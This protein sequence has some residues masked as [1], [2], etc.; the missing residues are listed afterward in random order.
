MNEF[1]L[2]RRLAPELLLDWLRPM[3]GFLESQGLSWSEIG[4]SP[5]DCDSLAEILM[6]GDSRMPRALVDS[7]C[8]IQGMAHPV[9]MDALIEAAQSQGLDLAGA[10][11]MTPENIAVRA[12]LISPSLIEEVHT[13]RLVSRRRAFVHFSTAQ[14]PPPAFPAPT[15][16]R[17]RALEQRLNVFY[18]AWNRGGGARVFTCSRLSEW[19]FLVRHGLPLRRQE[20]LHDE[21]ITS[22]CFRPVG[23]DVL[24][25]DTERGRLRVHCCAVRERSVLLRA[26]GSCFFGEP[27]FFPGLPHYTLAPVLLAGRS[28]LACADVPGIERISLTELEIYSPGAPHDRITITSEDVF[29]S[30]ESGRVERPQHSEDLTRATFT[31]RFARARRPRNFTVIPCNKVVYSRDTDSLLLRPWL[32]ERRFIRPAFP[33]ITK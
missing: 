10:Y 22:V 15:R 5:L 7:L 14:D 13:R 16:D 33:Q 31:V 23:Y 24:A 4:A 18:R 32:E 9:G 19:W 29:R 12:W 28:C 26:F 3:R 25:Y 27:N 11:E 17:L 8:L 1:K 30:L 21:E 2:L 20:A 6:G